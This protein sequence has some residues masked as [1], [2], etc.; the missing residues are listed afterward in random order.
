MMDIEKEKKLNQEIHK[1]QEQIA[2]L[3]TKLANT[4]YTSKAPA[5]VVEKIEIN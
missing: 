3:E 1:L 4:E 5:Q 2:R